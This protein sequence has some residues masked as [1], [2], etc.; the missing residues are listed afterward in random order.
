MIGH[1][2]K[3]KDFSEEDARALLVQVEGAGYNPPRRERILQW[4]KGQDFP[5]CPHRDDPDA[6]NVYK[7]LQFPDEVYQHIAD[8]RQQK[9]E[10]QH[11]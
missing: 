1:L 7:N 3:D 6:C 9:T 8:Y 4:Q 5:I 2:R 11:S 10:A